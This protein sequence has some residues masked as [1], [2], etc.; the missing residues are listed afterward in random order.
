MT[1]GRNEKKKELAKEVKKYLEE[2]KYFGYTDVVFESGNGKNKMTG[3]KADKENLKSGRE[4]YPEIERRLAAGELLTLEETARIVSV[5]IKCRLSESRTMTVFGEGNPRANV[6][7]VGEGPGFDED[8]QG[9]PFVGRAGQLLT[10]IIESTGLKREDVFITNVVKCHPMVDPS[11]PDRRGNDR[12]PSKD[13]AAACRPYLEQQLRNIRPKVV[14]TLG[15][16]AAQLLL[17]T[18]TG[19]TRLR[20]RFYDLR[21]IKLMPT[22]HPAALLR[23]SD[24]KKDVWN[25]MKMLKKELGI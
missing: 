16:S 12:P 14:V 21:G 3:D 18:D 25:D 23:N 19:I 5:C 11:N 2:E 1:A 13:E 7:F 9:M 4:L 24:L 17:E 10:K 15:N 20:G 22:F 6:M 8:R